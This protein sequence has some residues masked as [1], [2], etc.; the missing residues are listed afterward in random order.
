MPDTCPANNQAPP[1]IRG[2]RAVNPAHGGGL[3]PV[4]VSSAPPQVDRAAKLAAE[5][6]AQYG[7][8][9][10]ARHRALVHRIAARLEAGADA[11][12]ERAH[13]ETALPAAR[14]Q[15]E[16]ARTCFQLRM[17]GDI[18]AEGSWV[19][20]RIDH[21]DPQR[22]PQPKPN[23]RSMLRPLGPV[24]VFGASNFPL[25]YSVAGG[26]TASALAAG[27]PVLVKAHPAHPG[28]SDL[29]GH[30]VSEAVR[31]LGLPAGTFALLFDAATEVGAQLVQHPA[32]KAVG[33]TGSRRGGRALMDLAAAR[34]EP[35]PVHAEMGS[36]NPVFILPG[37]WRQRGEEIVACL[38]ASATL[39][40]G[41]FCTN[42]GLVLIDAD[43]TG[44]AFLHRLA[45]LM[46]ATPSGLMLTPAICDSY[47]RGVEARQQV[48]GVRTVS[49]VAAGSQGCSGGAALFATD[50]DTFLREPDLAQE[51]FGPTT[52]VVECRGLAQML[53]VAQA[54]EG[55]L[56]ASVHASETELPSAAPLARLLETKAGRLIYNGFP[57]GVEVCHSMVHGGP[58]PASSDARSTSVGGRALARFARPVSFQNWPDA[59]LPDVL[60]E[61]NP[62][63]LWRIVDGVLGRH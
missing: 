26:D 55:Q 57:T 34:P 7:W 24:A 53:E 12:I 44:E 54:L 18:A 21:A 3:E 47:R 31:E 58:Y 30:A 6:F 60:K 51:V 14:L 46:D 62:L 22:K 25:A 20:A 17:Y 1:A 43:E 16:L 38:H 23:L 2:F 42:P 4:F 56:T 36:V 19:D 9:A 45:A 8:M 32:I 41:Q 37:A 63:G 29:V 5:A 40:V 13:L 49:R 33:F 59:A 52:L 61:G 50:A 35:I 27:N 48:R 28:T 11:I 39:G 10:A 15:G